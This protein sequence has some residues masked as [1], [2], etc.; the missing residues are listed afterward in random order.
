[1]RKSPPTF[2]IPLAASYLSDSDVTLHSCSSSSGMS[3]VPPAH[4]SLYSAQSAS[5]CE[6]VIYEFFL[7]LESPHRREGHALAAWPAITFEFFAI[8]CNVVECQSIC[9][10]FV[11]LSSPPPLGADAACSF[12]RNISLSL[13]TEHQANPPQLH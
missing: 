7:L 4:L 5:R 12:Y 13:C 9:K 2:D 1:M 10:T 8:L 6:P 11:P 3:A